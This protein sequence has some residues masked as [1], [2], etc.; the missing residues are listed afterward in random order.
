MAGRE[1]TWLVWEERNPGAVTSSLG[2]CSGPT[3]GV[4]PRGLG[5]G[6]LACTDIAALVEGCDNAAH[7]IGLTLGPLP[8]PVSHVHLV[9]GL[10]GQQG[11]H[12]RP[13]HGC[14][15]CVAQCFCRDRAGDRDGAAGLEGGGSACCSCFLSTTSRRPP[16]SLSLPSGFLGS[17]PWDFRQ[18][19]DLSWSHVL[20]TCHLLCLPYP[21]T[22]P[23]CAARKFFLRVEHPFP[24]HTLLLRWLALAFRMRS[25]FTAMAI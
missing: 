11:L 19:H 2:S 13:G 23:I 25:K 14:V 9:E 24:H 16:V 7:L 21:P 4:L 8:S 20:L 22:W 3:D 10:L 18:F 15:I 1:E 5:E 6:V 12:Q 17:H